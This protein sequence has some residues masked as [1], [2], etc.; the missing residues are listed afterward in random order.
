MRVSV[1]DVSR[2]NSFDIITGWMVLHGVSGSDKVLFTMASLTAEVV[3]K[4][5]LAATQA[6]D[7]ST[8]TTEL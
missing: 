7:D 1:A 2:R 8:R 6:Q 4:A 3:L 5:A